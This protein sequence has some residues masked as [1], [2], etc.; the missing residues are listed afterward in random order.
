[1][2]KYIL[3]TTLA[4]LANSCKERGPVSAKS[5]KGRVVVDI[6]KYTDPSIKYNS[7]W[8]KNEKTGKSDYCKVLRID[9]DNWN[10]KDTIK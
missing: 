5:L 7:V 3:A 8:V 4:I 10:V 1:M 2:G 6:R 9:S